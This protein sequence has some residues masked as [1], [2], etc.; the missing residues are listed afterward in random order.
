M[1]DSSELYKQFGLA[2]PEPFGSKL[3]L[4]IGEENNEIRLIIKHHLEKL[5]FFNIRSSRNGYLALAE[6]KQTPADVV[7]EGDDLLHLNAYDLL[8]ELSED[9]QARRPAFIVISKPLNKSE[10]ML[11]LENGADEVMLRPFVQADLFPKIKRAYENFIS[12]KNPERIYEY[13]KAKIR[14]NNLEE[15]TSVYTAISTHSDKAARPLVGLARVLILKKKYEE[16][17]QFLSKAIERNENY[18]HAF[19]LRGEVYTTL[20]NYEK[21]LDDF[22]KAVTLSPLNITRYEKAAE[23]LIQEN[24]IEEC[25]QIL[26]IGIAAGL[27]H[28]YIIERTGYCYFVKKEYTKAIHY[29]KEA[30]RLEQDNVS[31]LNSLAICYRD[32]KELEKAVQTYNVILKKQPD[33][34]LILFN[35]AIALLVWEKKDDAIKILH[36]VLKIS[37]EYTKAKEKLQEL[38]VSQL[39]GAA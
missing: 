35:K 24:K 5:G 13:A 4:H 22:K 3:A 10:L 39:S 20:K 29:L 32:S 31:F 37:P 38:G 26:T 25:L 8:K 11:A 34:H 7:I 12:T 14:E 16:A 21:A 1:A 18:V 17:L 28:P 36:R 23:F 33:N 2:I 27:K 15:A 19:S 30:V 6:L 9:V